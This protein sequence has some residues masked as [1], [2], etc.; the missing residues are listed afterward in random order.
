MESAMIKN[1]I[2]RNFE[3]LLHE[4]YPYLQVV[5]KWK[6]KMWH[7]DGHLVV[8]LIFSSKKYKLC[9]FN[10][11]MIKLGKRQN[12]S[13]SVFSENIEYSYEQNVNWEEVDSIIKSTIA[14]YN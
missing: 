11:P 4:K 8:S 12:W 1:D 6:Q 9:F 3:L 13:T 2:Q 5:D 14:N 10:N 7:K